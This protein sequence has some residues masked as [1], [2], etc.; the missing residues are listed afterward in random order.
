LNSIESGSEP[1]INQSKSLF[2]KLLKV[3]FDTDGN[4]QSVQ[5]F[6]KGIITQLS[7]DKF[8]G[9]GGNLVIK[10]FSPTILLEEGRKYGTFCDITI[11][12]CVR[13]VMQDIPSNL[14]EANCDP[15]TDGNLGY[16][17]Q[18]KQSSFAYLQELAK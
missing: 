5:Y 14:M 9:I 1:L 7:V 8:Q 10:G 3:G 16:R 2:G 12:E 4:N 18:Y 17:I 13:R 11:S 15:Q 6:F